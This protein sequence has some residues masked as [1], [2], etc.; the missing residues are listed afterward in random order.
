[1]LLLSVFIQ[2]GN[3]RLENV[4]NMKRSVF[5]NGRQGLCRI[6]IRRRSNKKQTKHRIRHRRA[7]SKKGKKNDN[8]ET[9]S[10]CNMKQSSH[11]HFCCQGFL[12]SFRVQS[13]RPHIK[14]GQNPQS[15]PHARARHDLAGHLATSKERKMQ[16]TC[17]YELKN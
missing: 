2:I 6:F 14:L 16:K 9:N 7:S 12:V 4:L 10:N 3:F 11:L 8:S 17:Y 5:L 13:F 15:C 1:M